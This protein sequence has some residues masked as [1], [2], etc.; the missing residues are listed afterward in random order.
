[1]CTSPLGATWLSSLVGSGT[2]QIV[3]GGGYEPCATLSGV[4]GAF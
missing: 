3:V 4:G 2:R 1:M